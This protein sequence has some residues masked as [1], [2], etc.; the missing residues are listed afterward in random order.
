MVS[1]GTQIRTPDGYVNNP[2]RQT[3]RLLNVTGALVPKGSA[4]R[5]STTVSRAFLLH[6]GTFDERV[7][8][9]TLLDCRPN[10]RVECVY[11][12]E[13]LALVNSPVGPG[14]SLVPSATPGLLTPF[15]GGGFFAQVAWTLEGVTAPGLVPVLF[16]PPSEVF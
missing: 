9:S 6:T 4:V 2:N 3:L 14:I 7:I 13:T 8:G 15:G 11:S 5:L 12:G 1:P 10:E 16:A